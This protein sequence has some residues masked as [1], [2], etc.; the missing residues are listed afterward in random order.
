M[1][2]PS[3]KDQLKDDRTG[4]KDA[5]VNNAHAP[6]QYQPRN[7]QQVKYFHSLSTSA[8]KIGRDAIVNLH[9]LAYMI[10]GLVWSI[11]TFPDLIVCLGLTQ[12][13]QFASANT[14]AV[15]SYD[16]TF[17][18]G[19][20]YLS[21]LVL[22]CSF[23]V[24]R[25]VMPVAFVLHERKFDTVHHV[26]FQHFLTKCT[27]MK[28]A[29]VVTDGEAGI[30]KA[31]QAVMPEWKLAT[32][33]NHIIRDVEFWLKKHAARS[34]DISVY[35]NQIR[36][37]LACETEVLLQRKSSMFQEHWSAAVIDYYQNHL[38]GRIDRA[39]TAYLLQCGLDGA[40]ITTNSSESM[41]AMLKHFQVH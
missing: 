15:L 8:Q 26:F 25:P 1:T 24:E 16:T 41:N 20:F 35:K 40:G 6:A 29:C 27:H 3:T 4:Y 34:E 37:L 2:A 31:V 33:W 7:A 10:P 5:L 11:T 18:L 21:F 13:L 36:E 14:D 28:N 32:C 30:V 39:Y 19:D 23:F 9:E 17:C 12:L 38:R 22:S